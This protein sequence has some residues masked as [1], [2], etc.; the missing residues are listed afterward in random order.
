MVIGM[1]STIL[2]Q[3]FRYYSTMNSDIAGALILGLTK[4]NKL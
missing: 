2:K 1:F 4:V 3:N